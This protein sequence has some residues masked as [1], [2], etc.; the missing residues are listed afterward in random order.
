MLQAVE[1]EPSVSI[2]DQHN[3]KLANITNNF[4][5]TDKSPRNSLLVNSS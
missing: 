5:I 2:N 4:S 1:R 3:F